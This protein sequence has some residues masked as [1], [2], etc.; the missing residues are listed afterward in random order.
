MKYFFKIFA[1]SLLVLLISYITLEILLASLPF[2]K[3]FVD[4]G[5]FRRWVSIPFIVFY[6][7]VQLFFYTAQFALCIRTKF[8]TA[9]GSEKYFAILLAIIC[10]QIFSFAGSMEFE[11]MISIA[12]P[13]RYIILCCDSSG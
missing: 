10:V 9:V 6:I 7:L 11:N 1:I 8:F 3:Y 2:G 13:C 5:D 12:L 4:F